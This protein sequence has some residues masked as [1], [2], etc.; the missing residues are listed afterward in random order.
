MT[1][2]WE[3]GPDVSI[4]MRIAGHSSEVVSQLSVQ[5]SPA[6]IEE[7]FDRLEAFNGKTRRELAEGKERLLTTASST[8]DNHRVDDEKWVI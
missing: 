7:T 6:S 2:L 8:E 1:R 3:G 5:P 4:V